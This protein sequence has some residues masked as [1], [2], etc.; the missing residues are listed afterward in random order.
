[1]S[2]TIRVPVVGSGVTRAVSPSIGVMIATM[3]STLQCL[4][5]MNRWTTSFL[6]SILSSESSAVT[7]SMG[8]SSFLIQVVIDSMS[9]GRALTMIHLRCGSGIKSADCSLTALG[10]QGRLLLRNFERST[11]MA[12]TDQFEVLRSRP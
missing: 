3:R 7:V 11:R 12:R 9:S 8:L 2:T 6:F 4:S 1:M 10:V 5:L